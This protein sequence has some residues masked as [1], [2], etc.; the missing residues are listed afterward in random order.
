MTLLSVPKLAF[1]AGLTLA[2]A[3]PIS[4]PAMAQV[5][6]PVAPPAAARTAPAHIL[7]KVDDLRVVRGGVHPRWQKLADFLKARKVKAGIG[8]ICDSLEGDNPNYVRWIKEQR[9]TGLI[10]FWNHGYNHKEWTVEGRK[11]QEFVGTSYEQQKESF[12]QSSRL[13]KEKLGF[14]LPAFGAPFN[15]TDA[16]T[17]RVL[18]EDTDTRVWL[19]GDV[20]NPAGKLV[21]DRVGPVNIENPIFKPSLEKFVAGYDRYPKR[22][23]F[24]I[25][26]HPAQWDDAGFDQFVKIVDFLTKEGAIFTTPSEYAKTAAAPAPVTKP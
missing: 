18:Q 16:T 9:A 2:F 24:V 15:G 26:G 25:Q 8:I 23:Y 14:S 1:T 3:L 21:L 13:A 11:T 22:A 7:I 4:S 17:V 19:Y 5:A 6:T 12:T 20:K 10:E